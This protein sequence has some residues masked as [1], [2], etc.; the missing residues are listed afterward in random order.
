MA[1]KDLAANLGQSV[2][3]Y[4]ICAT[5][6]ALENMAAEDATTLRALLADRGIRFKDLAGA[7][8][9]DNDSPTIHWEALSRHARGGCT[10]REKLRA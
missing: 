8:E 1:L 2:A 7:L 10:A 5:C 9:A 4:G 6:H 3:P